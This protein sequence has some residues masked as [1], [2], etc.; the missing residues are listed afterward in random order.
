MRVTVCQFHDDAAGLERDWHGLVAHVRSERSDFVLLPEMPFFPWFA[1]KR[2]FDAALWKAAVAAHSAWEQRLSELSPAVVASTRPIDFG[3]ERYNE[4]FLWERETGSRAAHAKAYLP[5]EEGVWEASWYQ[6][7]TPDF[8]PVQV[9][10]AHVGFLICTELWHMEQARLYGLEQVQ[11]LVTPRLTA[12]VT[13]EKW[14]AAGRVAAIVAGAFGLSSNRFAE[15]GLY[16]GRGWIVDPEGAV[17]ALTSEEQ[18]F[19]SA[20]ID[21]DV[22]DRAKTTYPR[23]AIAAAPSVASG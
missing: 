12:E 4:G 18:P 14:L 10:E 23:Y 17:L 6:A 15:S 20:T 19:V 9:R 5:D 21:L 7:A 22:A 3:N 11:L 1:T 16:G 8:T 2:T 13:L